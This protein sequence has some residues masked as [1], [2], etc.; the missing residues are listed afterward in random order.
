LS[1]D[2]LYNSLRLCIYQENIHFP[3]YHYKCIQVLYWEE[4]KKGI[5]WGRE[6]N[7]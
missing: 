7:Q 4:N 1:I 6:D 2:N 5:C 3:L